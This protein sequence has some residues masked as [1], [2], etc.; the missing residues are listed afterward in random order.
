MA[1]LRP[2]TS[3]PPFP[4]KQ[5]FEIPPGGPVRMYWERMHVAKEDEFKGITPDG[6]VAPELFSIKKTGVSVQPIIDADK[7]FTAS[8]T[9]G[10]K[11]IA[12]FNVDD[13]AWRMWCNIHPYLI[14]HGV[15]LDDVGDSQR[16]RALDL[17]GASMSAAGF[18][19]ARDVMK[20]NEHILEITG[21]DTEYGEWVYWM[22]VFGEPSA[23]EP[24]GW[25][26]DGH[27]LIVNCLVLGDQ[28]VMTPNFMGSEPVTAESGKYAGT[29]VFRDEESLGLAMM[30]SLT[31]AQQ[32][33]AR[34]G[35]KLP[36]DC[37][38]TAFHDNEHI[39]YEGIPYGE[40]TAEQKKLLHKL[41]E[42]YVGRIRPGHAEI[43][44][45]EVMNHIDE[46]WF[47]WIGEVD[48]TSPFYYRVHSPVIL[49]EFDDQPGIAL[50]NDDHTRNHIHTLVRTPNGNDYG[51][52]LLRQ[53][54][55]DFDHSHPHTPHRMGNPRAAK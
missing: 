12:L 39:K 23:T 21:R 1:N 24:W 8:L 20:L 53:H 19:T 36:F 37:F 27:H 35:M 31:P 45:E 26:I 49:I 29:T 3:R 33:K 41:I 4:A 18:K 5:A 13:R 32:E 47:A 43:R 51:K 50:D 16:A 40:L 15:C 9:E 48:D 52:D 30:R 54:Y 2:R 44:L 38:T 25:Q 46:T 28:I 42:L 55:E 6:E 22:S 11:S 34:I 7:A 17:V 10:E 14:R